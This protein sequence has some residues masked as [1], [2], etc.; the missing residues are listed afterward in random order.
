MS[1]ETVPDGTEVRMSLR[2]VSWVLLA[3]VGVAVLLR[4]AAPR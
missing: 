1:I 4:L 2:T 3:L